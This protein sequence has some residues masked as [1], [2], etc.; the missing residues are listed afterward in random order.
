[1]L[2]RQAP[3]F[4]SVQ[5]QGH[6]QQEDVY[7]GNLWQTMFG[8]MGVEVPENFQGVEADGVIKPLV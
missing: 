1:M 3:L 6:I 8:F 5:H 7:L 2:Q 4:L